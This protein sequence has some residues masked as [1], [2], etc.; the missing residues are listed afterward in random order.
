MSR[1]VLDSFVVLLLLLVGISLIGN[2]E[3]SES[4]QVSINAVIEDFESDVN[5][6][7]VIKDGYNVVDETSYS[8]NRLSDV[9]STIGGFI[10][11]GASFALDIVQKLVRSVIG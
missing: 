5:N 8:S 7:E 9:T 4:E 1:F 10:V 3:D 11:D 2:S 6:G